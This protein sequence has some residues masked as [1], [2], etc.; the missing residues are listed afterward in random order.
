MDNSRCTARAR[1]PTASRSLVRTCSARRL[2]NSS[3]MR[4][5]DSAQSKRVRKFVFEGK[6]RTHFFSW[7]LTKTLR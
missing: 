4:R 6:R 5:L 2:R 7:A 3:L 1:R